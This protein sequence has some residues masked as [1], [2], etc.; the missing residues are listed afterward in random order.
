MEYYKDLK[1]VPPE[2]MEYYIENGE[3]RFREIKKN[4]TYDDISYNLFYGKVHHY[5]SSS[6]VEKPIEAECGTIV[7]HNWPAR[8]TS[9][10]QAEKLLAINKLMNVAKYL[11]GDWKPNWNNN[12]KEYKYY[13]WYLPIN[14]NLAIC[15]T[16]SKCT[17]IVFFKSKELAQ[18][19]I[20]ILGEETIKL[21]LCT[22]W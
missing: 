19:A 6:N 22:D 3:V 5:I 14:N 17:S 21:A 13:I 1:I 9:K 10:K 8:C 11:N 20:D 18:Q 4:L 2:G 15:N 7:Y 16:I 12:N